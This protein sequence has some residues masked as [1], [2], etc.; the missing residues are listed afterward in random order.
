MIVISEDE[1]D[2][3]VI[4]KKNQ[5]RKMQATLNKMKHQEYIKNLNEDGK[6]Y[7]PF[8]EDDD[9]AQQSVQAQSPKE[10]SEYNEG[11]GALIG[12]NLSHT[13]GGHNKTPVPDFNEEKSNSNSILADSRV[14]PAYQPIA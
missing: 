11:G 13:N 6:I 3:P 8:R 14:K 4:V 1:S 12:D 10:L 5:Q 2:E 7:D 9:H